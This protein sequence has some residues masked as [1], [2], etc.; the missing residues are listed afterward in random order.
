MLIIAMSLS[1]VGALFSS[2]LDRV[3]EARL[4]TRAMMLAETKLAEMQ[5][6][7]GDITEGTEGDFA[8]KPAKFYWATKMDPTDVPEMNRLT[9]TIHYDDPGD[10]F[11]YQI[12]RYFSP[13]LNYSYEALKQIATDPSKLEE[14]ESPGFKELMTMLAESEMPGG[15]QLLK[16]LLAGGVNEMIRLYNRMLTGKLSL[17]DLM[18]QTQVGLDEDDDEPL[19]AMLASGAAEP[20]YGLTWTNSDTAEVDKEAK[21]ARADD[22][23]S[24]AETQ[25]AV[26]EQASGTPAVGPAARSRRRRGSRAAPEGDDETLPRE[27]SREQAMRN[28]MRMLG[29]MARR[30]R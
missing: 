23:T 17:G 29:R 22:K 13:G 8:D 3:R 27:M 7:L 30:K 18:S 11:D 25:P 4:R 9:L 6:G 1:A 15:E 2:S 20:S 26:D 10:R 12:Y 21:L 24:E 5:L 16:A 28:I 19:A 14:L